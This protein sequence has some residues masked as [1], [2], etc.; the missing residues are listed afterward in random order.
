M[1]WTRV[2]LAL[3]GAGLAVSVVDWFFF[4][5]LFHEKY[6]AFPEVWRRPRGGAG[7]GRAIA[8]SAVASLLTPVVFVYLQARTGSTLTHAL[9]L[10]VAV[11]LMAPVPMLVGQYLFMKLHPLV[12]TGHAVGWLAK[13]VVSAAVANWL[14]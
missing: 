11:W 1:S 8:L 6:S 4:G 13:L 5:V 14:L 2:V 9:G 10:A 7:E 3:A 12:T